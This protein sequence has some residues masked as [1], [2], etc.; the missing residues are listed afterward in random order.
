MQHPGEA[1][2]HPRPGARHV[3]ARALAL[4]SIACRAAL[5]QDPG[6]PEAEAM[7]LRLRAWLDATHLMAAL[8]PAEVELITTPLGRLADKAAIDAS[9]RAEGLYVLA[10]AMDLQP[11]LAHD[12]LVDPV[13]AAEVVGFLHDTPLDRDPAPQL[14]GERALDTFAAQQLALHWRLRDWQLHPQPMDFAAFVRE[15]SWASLDVDESALLDGDLAIEG[16]RIDQADDEQL[17]RCL[18]IA[19]ER[20]QAANWLLGGDPLYSN[21]DTST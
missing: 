1:G 13:A 15:C 16:V 20:H 18:S 14:R 6:D 2:L 5:E 8:E 9:W 7:H 19:G 11:G 3:H 4:A 12:R 21:V 10:W 17:Q